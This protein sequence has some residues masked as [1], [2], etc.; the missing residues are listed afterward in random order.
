M[1]WQV[2]IP[3]QN[4]KKETGRDGRDHDSAGPRGVWCLW[5]PWYPLCE[6][7]ED[8]GTMPGPYD[9]NWVIPLHSL[10]MVPGNVK[11]WKLQPR[12]P[13]IGQ[14]YHQMRSCVC[15][16]AP[17]ECTTTDLWSRRMDVPWPQKEGRY[18]NWPPKTSGITWW[19][20]LFSGFLQKVFGV[21]CIPFVVRYSSRWRNWC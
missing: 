2:N 4:V 11:G 9:L 5:L 14:Y 18:S 10:L 8:S 20:E 13:D 17:L 16:H 3:W 6:H 19:I 15:Q 12:L 21:R 7:E 1:G